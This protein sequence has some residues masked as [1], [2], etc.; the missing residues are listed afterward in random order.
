[1]CFAFSF[2]FFLF[3]IYIFLKTLISPQIGPIRGCFSPFRTE[4]GI[5][6]KKKKRIHLGWVC[7]PVDGHIARLC[8]SDA[9][10]ALLELHPCFPDNHCDN[11]SCNMT[12]AK[13]VLNHLEKLKKISYQISCDSFFE[14][15]SW[16]IQCSIR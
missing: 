16:K 3:F 8:L 14:H 4:L 13:F 11:F 2:Y 9:G 1:M 12:N 6:K 10:A 15:V 5:R 7:S